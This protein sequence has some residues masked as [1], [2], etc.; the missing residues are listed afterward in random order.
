M[1]RDGDVRA[2]V[3]VVDGRLVL[4]WQRRTVASW[5]QGGTRPLTF[6]E[7]VGWRLAGRTPKP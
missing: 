4:T 3:R 5:E 2:W 7:R 6:T 1:T